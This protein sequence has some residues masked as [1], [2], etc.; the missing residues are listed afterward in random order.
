MYIYLV[1]TRFVGGKLISKI[2]FGFGAA[3]LS[4]FVSAR[5]LDGECALLL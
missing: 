3:L 2:W 5:A 4:L 1:F